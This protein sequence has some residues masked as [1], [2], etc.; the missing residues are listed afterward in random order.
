MRHVKNIGITPDL[1]D[2]IEDIVMAQI[3]GE[4]IA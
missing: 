4:I 3:R 1:Y 2:P